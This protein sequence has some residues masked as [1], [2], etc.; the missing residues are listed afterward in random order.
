MPMIVRCAGARTLVALAIP[1][2]TF[3]RRHVQASSKSGK[4]NRRRRRNRKEGSTAVSGVSRD[5]NDVSIDALT[6]DT[7]TQSTRSSLARFV[8]ASTKSPRHCA[9][10]WHLLRRRPRPGMWVP[11]PTPSCSTHKFCCKIPRRIC[12]S[13]KTSEPGLPRLCPALGT[14]APV[15]VVDPG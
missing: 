5:H 9:L 1:S 4:R 15:R 12:H 11:L 13:E 6:D 10:T 7:L 8:A 3:R 14:A 2:A